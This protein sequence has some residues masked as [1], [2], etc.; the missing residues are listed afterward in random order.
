MDPK[1]LAVLR[2]SGIGGFL[3]RTGRLTVSKARRPA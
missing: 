2:P 3:E 1:R